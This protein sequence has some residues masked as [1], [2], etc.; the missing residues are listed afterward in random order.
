MLV[1]IGLIVGGVLVGRDLIAASSVRAQISQFQDYATAV[2]T[3]RGKYS[4]IPGDCDTASQFG[5]GSGGNGNGLLEQSYS[6]S[7]VATSP[8]RSWAQELPKFF[9]HLA[10]SGLIKFNSDGTFVLGRGYPRLAINNA[11]GMI[12]AGQWQAGDTGTIPG[13][14]LDTYNFPQGLWLHAI[15]C[16]SAATSPA[17]ANDDCGV[18]SIAQAKG[19]DNK[20][21]DGKPVSGKIW[22]YAA[23]TLGTVCSNAS[24][25]YLTTAGNVCQ[26]S[27]KMD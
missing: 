11:A 9:I 19:I 10:A 3:F 12:A 27:Y 14:L 4:C 23:A 18:L 7:T 26:L 15:V 1:I 21:D 20:V 2:N 5:L 25:T 22:A 17:I 6:D 13:Y 24:N 16:N 8:D